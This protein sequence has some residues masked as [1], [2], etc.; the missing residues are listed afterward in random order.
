MPASYQGVA[1]FVSSAIGAYLVL[2]W[3]GAWLR[4][5]RAS[6]RDAGSPGFVLALLIAVGIGLHNFGE[7]LAIGA[8]YALGEAALGTLLVIGFTLHNT[9]EGLAIVAPIAKERPSVWTLVKLGLIGGLPTIAGAWVG[10]LVYSQVL[11]VVFLGLGAGAIASGGVADRAAGRWRAAAAGAICNRAGHGRPARGL[12]RDVR[13]RPTG[14][15]TM[16]HILRSRSGP[17]LLVAR[18]RSGD[19]ARDWPATRSTAGDD[20]S[21]VRVIH[22]VARDMTFYVGGTV[23]AQSDDPCAAPASASASFS[24]TPTSACRTTSRS[25]RG[26]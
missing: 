13:H 19:R 9:T 5:R 14:R 18:R 8:A 17:R 1:L 16:K 25:A 12:R 21:A 15:M 6:A 4:A 3:F 20:A 11:G 24:A 2:E 22:L 7:G 26:A 23:R 10:G